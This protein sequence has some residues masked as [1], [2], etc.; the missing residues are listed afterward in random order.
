MD[1]TYMAA[2]PLRDRRYSALLTDLYQLTMAL[3]HWKSGHHE[4]EA[5][6]HLFFRNQPFKGGFSIAC[7]L[8]DAIE[9]LQNLAFTEDELA[10][11]GTLTGSDG[12][13]LFDAGFLAYLRDFEW[14]C[15]VDA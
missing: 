15:D 13:A 2:T 10:Y 4:K 9:Y 6:F 14:Q 1:D 11:L 12:R 3:A 5:V 7:G 8:E